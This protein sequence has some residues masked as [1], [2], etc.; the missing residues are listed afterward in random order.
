M[1]LGVNPTR[2]RSILEKEAQMAIVLTTKGDPLLQTLV[3][4]MKSLRE[5][6]VVVTM[7]VLN[8]KSLF[9]QEIP[10]TN[11]NLQ[12]LET[13]DIMIVNMIITATKEIDTQIIQFRGNR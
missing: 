2:T 10:A 8:R 6:K 4:E 12:Y 13:Q 3:K 1:T 7:L 11:T 5:D 9:K